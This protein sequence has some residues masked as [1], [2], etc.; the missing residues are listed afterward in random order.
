MALQSLYA[1]QRGLLCFTTGYSLWVILEEKKWWL[2]ETGIRGEANDSEETEVQLCPITPPSHQ[3][4]QTQ[5]ALTPPLCI[6]LQFPNDQKQK[7]RKTFFFLSQ[8]TNTV[9]LAWSRKAPQNLISSDQGINHRNFMMMLLVCSSHQ[10]SIKHHET[11]KYL[12]HGF[13]IVTSYTEYKS[14]RGR[15][16][17]PVR[18][19]YSVAL[20]ML[21]LRFIHELYTVMRHFMVIF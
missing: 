18:K 4:P 9:I 16:S 2:N 1:N 5:E 8:I 3:M 7:L 10:W 21:E 20:I 11:T 17:L 19:C 6:H 15:V 13:Q 12:K 14:P